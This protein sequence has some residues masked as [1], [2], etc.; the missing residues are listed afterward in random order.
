[1]AL[2][3]VLSLSKRGMELDLRLRALELHLPLM[4]LPLLLDP[5]LA[6]YLNLQ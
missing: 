6:Q 2:K 1:M 3:R 4:L 5:L